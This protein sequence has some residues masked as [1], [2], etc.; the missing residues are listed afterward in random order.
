MMC[1]TMVQNSQVC[2]VQNFCIKGGQ[3]LLS[4]P[5]TREKKHFFHFK[6]YN[7]TIRAWLEVQKNNFFSFGLLDLEVAVLGCFWRKMA[8]VL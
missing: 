8:F 5:G 7:L 2:V 3:T 1:I 6:R 4:L